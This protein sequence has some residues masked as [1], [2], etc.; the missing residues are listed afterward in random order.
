MKFV[1]VNRKKSGA[2]AKLSSKI[3][4]QVWDWADFLRCGGSLSAFLTARSVSSRLLRRLIAGGAGGG[5]FFVMLSERRA[6]DRHN[7]IKPL[8][9]S[10]LSVIRRRDALIHLPK[11]APQSNQNSVDF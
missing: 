4:G 9:I 10:A 2:D 7:H 8:G 5:N 3:N 1:V 6:S 11:R